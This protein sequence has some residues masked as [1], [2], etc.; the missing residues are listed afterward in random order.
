MH[1]EL[2]DSDGYPIVEFMEGLEMVPGDCSVVSNNLVIKLPKSELA[3]SSKS[4]SVSNSNVELHKMSE[5]SDVNNNPVESHEV[6]DDG[7]QLKDLSS[8]VSIEVSS[9]HDHDVL[10]YF[11]DSLLVS[12]EG[13]PLHHIVDLTLSDE[14]RDVPPINISSGTNTDVNEDCFSIY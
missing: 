11:P 12:S 4:S 14:P 8:N 13:P 10:Y 2:K 9:T 3:A 1:E 7:D 6:V 5:V